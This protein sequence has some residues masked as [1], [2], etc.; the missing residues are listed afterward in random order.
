MSAVEWAD[1]CELPVYILSC[2]PRPLGH[3]PTQAHHVAFDLYAHIA[4]TA[5]VKINKGNKGFY[6]CSGSGHFGMDP[7][8]RIRTSD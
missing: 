3:Q 1:V 8:P 7:D 2:L 6:Q 5:N 4:C